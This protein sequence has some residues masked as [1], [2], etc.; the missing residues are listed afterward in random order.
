M[1]TADSTIY[2]DHNA[3]T[4][5]HPEVR[6]AMLPWIGERWGNPSSGHVFGRQAREALEAAR[7]EVAALIGASAASI[8]FTSGGTE[9]DNLALLGASDGPGRLITTAVEHPAITG[10]AS[11]LSARGWTWEQLKV[12]G[13]GVVDLD[14][15]EEAL[16]GPATLVSV[17]AAQ[18][19]TGAIQP[20]SEL[21]ALARA[22]STAVIV[23]SDAAQAVG[24]IAVDV[25]ALDVD[26]LTIAGH[27]LCGPAGIGALYVRP[28]VQL[29]PQLLGGGQEGGLRPGTEPIAQIVGLGAAAALARRTLHNEVLRQHALRELLWRRLH[30]AIPG[31][32]RTVPG[33]LALPNTLHLCVP[34]V[35][36]AELLAGAPEVAASTG[37][38]CHGPDGSGGVLAAMGLSA[39]LAAGALRLSLGRSSDEVAIIGAS[40]A[41]IQAWRRLEP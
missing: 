29:R 11:R 5:I 8:V 32:H 6:E 1:L 22:A 36:G 24:K 7:A 4:P 19:E 13:D 14:A 10:P 41:L 38:A 18:N 15:A 23:H 28:G 37:S 16:R 17:I 12:N 27:K 35:R 9:A 33:D 20:V 25:R 40:E 30:A 31:I 2:L 26:L 39:A 3:T 21:A 34:G